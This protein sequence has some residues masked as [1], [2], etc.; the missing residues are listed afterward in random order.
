MCKR[1]INSSA[2]KTTLF[3]RLAG[4]FVLAA[5]LLLVTSFAATTLAQAQEINFGIISTESSQNLRKLWDPFLDD[6][7]KSTGLDI[8]A[9]FASDYAGI[10]EGMRFNKVQLAWYGNKSAMEAV[11]RADGEVFMQTL[12]ADGSQGYYSHIIANVNSPINSL[13]DMFKDS[14]NLNFGNGDPNST[15][16]FLVP[17]YY[18][19]AVNGVDPKTAF[20][21]MLSSNHESNALSVANGQVDVATNNSESLDRLELTAPDKRKQIKVIW[22]SPLIPSDPL[23]WRKDLDP[24]IKK[25]IQDFLLSYGTKGDA[26]EQ[27]IL[28]ALQWK[29]FKNSSNDQLLPIRQLELFKEKKTIEDRGNLNNEQKTRLTQI[30]NELKD[31]ETKMASLAKS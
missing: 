11:D 27:E 26:R 8:K 31:L 13:E 21:R 6:M 10:I 14:K 9:F 29:G 17:S 1:V 25:K 2:K 18:V 5:T 28:T 16:G 20:K 19:F 30:E 24:A 12:A 22:T 3:S 15:S 4:L 23:V 7:R